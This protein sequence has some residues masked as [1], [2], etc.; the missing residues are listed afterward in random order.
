MKTYPILKLLTDVEVERMLAPE[1]RQVCVDDKYAP[2]MLCADTEIYRNC[3]P[4]S[5]VV[6]IFPS[7]VPYVIAGYLIGRGGFTRD[8]IY[9]MADEFTDDNDKGKIKPEDLA[10]IVRL[11][12]EG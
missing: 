11:S 3:C 6:D 1:Y 4:F 2:S 7:P 12:R 9:R 10:E 8:E 5:F